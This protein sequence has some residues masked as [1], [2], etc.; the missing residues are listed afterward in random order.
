MTDPVPYEYSAMPMDALSEALHLGDCAPH[1]GGDPDAWFPPG[2][3]A[4]S[5]QA[6]AASARLAKE[7]CADCP[8]RLE[9]LEF[10]LRSPLGAFGVWGGTAAWERRA[11]RA[12]RVAITQ[13]D[14]AA[15]STDVTDV[16]ILDEFA[17]VA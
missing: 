2:D 16:E 14:H 6:L 9:C 17:G 11:I 13:I 3:A 5:G 1:H 4:T 15:D 10:S 8:V 7:L 12:G